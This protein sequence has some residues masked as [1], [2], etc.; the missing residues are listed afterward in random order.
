MVAKV[1]HLYNFVYSLL[2]PV[3]K[4][5]EVNVKEQ[6]FNNNTKGN[7]EM[8]TFNTIYEL[9]LLGIL[10]VDEVVSPIFVLYG[11]CTYKGWQSGFVTFSIRS[12]HYKFFSLI[13]KEL[14]IFSSFTIEDLSSENVAVFSVN[15]SVCFELFEQCEF[16]LMLLKEARLAKPSC[17]LD[18]SFTVKGKFPF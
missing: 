2:V 1:I 3:L 6:N 11:K 10:G 15:I 9:A 14:F 12:I 7:I 13:S 5:H 4:Q 17:D 18:K 16:S 8:C